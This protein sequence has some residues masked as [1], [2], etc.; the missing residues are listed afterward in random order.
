[1]N[2]NLQNQ[3]LTGWRSTNDEEWTKNV[4]GIGHENVTEAP[5]PW[6]SFS[7]YFFSLILSEICLLRVLNPSLQPPTPFYSQNRGGGC[8]PTC[9]AELVTYSRSNLMGLDGPS[10]EELPVNWSFH[11]HFEF[12]SHFLLKSHKILRIT[13]QLVLSSSTWLA[14]IRMSTCNCPQMKLGYDNTVFF[15]CFSWMKLVFLSHIGHAWCPLTLYPLK[16][17]YVGKSLIVQNTIDHNL[18]V[19]CRFPSNTSTPSSHNIFKSS[20][21]GVRYTSISSPSCLWPAIIIH[22]IMYFCKMHNQGRRL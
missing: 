18:K 19:C 16:F 20:I 10:A 12:F 21:N 6:F 8:R 3:K 2:S 1:M 5:R 22:R 4:H 14:K 15:P 9:L 11:P 7:F 13:R 17:P